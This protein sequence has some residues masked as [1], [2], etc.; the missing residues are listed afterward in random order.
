LSHW[1]KNE[2]YAVAKMRGALIAISPK[3]MIRNGTTVNT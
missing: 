2:S 1:T 3:A